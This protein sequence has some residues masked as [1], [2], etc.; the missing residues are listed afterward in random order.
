VIAG[1]SILLL[2]I[3]IVLVLVV[4]LDLSPWRLKKR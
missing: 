4:A 2:L 3:V 1:S